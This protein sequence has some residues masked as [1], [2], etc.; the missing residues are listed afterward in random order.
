MKRALITGITGQD[1][2]YLAEFLLGKPE[3]EVHG[4]VRRSS[5]LNRQRIDHIFRAVPKVGDRFQLHYADLADASS[6]SQ[7]VEHGPP[8][9]DLQPRCPEPR[10]SLVRPAPLHGRRRR[11]GYAPNSRSRPSPQPEPASQVLPGVQLRDVRLGSATSRSRHAVPS[12]KPLLLRQALCP[13]ADDQLPRGVRD[14]RLLGHP[15]QPREPPPRRVVRHP[16]DHPGGH[17]DQ[18]RAPE[19]ARHGQPR[20]QARLGLRRRLR[21]GHVADAPARQARRLRRRDGRDLLRQRV[22]RARLLGISTSTGTT[23]SSSTRSTPAR[24]RSTSF[25][26]TRPRRAKCLAGSPRSTSTG[27]SG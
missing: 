6:L 21:P 19:E 13:L 11:P 27:W 8:R 5:T 15:V 14:V 7:I 4:L 18:G 10:P 24:P 1:G 22:P 16:Q 25:W 2:S 3:Y 26:A 17:A 12:T 20:R 23:S 9:R